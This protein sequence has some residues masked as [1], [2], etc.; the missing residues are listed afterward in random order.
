[1]V[2]PGGVALAVGLGCHCSTWSR[3]ECLCPNLRVLLPPSLLPLPRLI[4]GGVQRDGEGIWYCRHCGEAVIAVLFHRR[5][6][7]P[8]LTLANAPLAREHRG[9][10]VP[11]RHWLPCWARCTGAPGDMAA[12]G[13]GL[14]PQL[15]ARRRSPSTCRPVLDTVYATFCREYLNTS[16][17]AIG[18]VPGEFRKGN[19]TQ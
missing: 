5:P 1:M 4:V 13:W 11:G 7:S 10:P 16:L 3:S 15:G 18:W 2:G 14:G 8:S 19:P 12:Q 6:A 9:P 17:L